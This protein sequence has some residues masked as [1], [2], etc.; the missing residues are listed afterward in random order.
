MSNYD[1]RQMTATSRRFNDIKSCEI[2]K[3]DERYGLTFTLPWGNETAQIKPMDFEI[4]K[5]KAGDWID[6][7][8]WTLS[9]QGCISLKSAQFIG[10]TPEP[11][12]PKK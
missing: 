7:K 5:Y 10:R 1:E 2:V 9:G 8:L 12:I 3:I 11:F 4:G 6:M